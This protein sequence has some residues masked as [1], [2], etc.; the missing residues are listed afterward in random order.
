MRFSFYRLH[1][2]TDAT[3]RIAARH[4]ERWFDLAD[5]DLGFSCGAPDVAAFDA[6]RRAAIVDKLQTSTAA[7]VDLASAVLLPPIAPDARIFCVGL[8]YADHAEESAMAKPEFPVVFLRTYDSFVGHGQ[9][10]VLPARSSAFDYEGEMV[11]VLGKGGRYIDAADAAGCIAGYSVANEG[12]VRDYQLKR[13][14]QWTMGKNFSRSGAMGPSLVTAD[15][16]P[17]LGGGLA[18]ATRL[19]GETVQS[20]NT[21]QLIFDVARIVAYLSEAFVLRAGDT[22]VTGTPAGVGA[23]RNPPL[24]MREGDTVEVEVEGIGLVRNTVAREQP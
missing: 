15:E 6:A 14:P 4:G 17:A 10:L 3:I 5:L 11:A 19:N 20:S 2:D 1:G 23:V 12:S 9:P 18:I 13:G 24:F 8:N 7:P 21:R 22:I 16:L